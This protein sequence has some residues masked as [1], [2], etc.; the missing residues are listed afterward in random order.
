[1]AVGGILQLV[2]IEG[3]LYWVAFGILVRSPPACRRSGFC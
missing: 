1:M 2:G 3:G